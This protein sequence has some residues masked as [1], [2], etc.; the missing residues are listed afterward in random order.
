MSQSPRVDSRGMPLHPSNTHRRVASTSFASV[1]LIV[2]GFFHG[3]QG[4]AA[5]LSDD[6]FTTAR[7]YFLGEDGSSWGWAH[8]ALG[9]LALAAGVA[10]RTRAPW[11][12][13]AAVIVATLSMFGNF[14][15]MPYSPVAACVLLA[16]DFFVM[17]AAFADMD[18]TAG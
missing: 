15:W 16:L 17:W 10:L 4:V 12:R 13:G 6:G 11:A 9:V 8:L 18:R 14:L 1:L 3:I 7:G 5:L 2:V